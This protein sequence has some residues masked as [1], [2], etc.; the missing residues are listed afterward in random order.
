MSGSNIRI[1]MFKV[2][3]VI[4]IVIYSIEG[5]LGIGIN[6]MSLCTFIKKIQYCWFKYINY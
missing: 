4:E 6:H 2:S 1:V 3:V 5:F